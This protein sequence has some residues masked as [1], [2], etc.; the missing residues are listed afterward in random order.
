MNCHIHPVLYDA[1]LR[2]HETLGAQIVHRRARKSFTSIEIIFDSEEGLI[3]N[4][5]GRINT[6]P[7]AEACGFWVICR[8]QTRKGYT[9]YNG[10]QVFQ[11]FLSPVHP[12]KRREREVTITTIIP[13]TFR[14]T[15]SHPAAQ[16]A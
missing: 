2:L 7:E 5:T 4:I 8:K 6:L 1:Y 14:K 3:K 11:L 10:L 12:K 15:T 16:T 13:V 9:H